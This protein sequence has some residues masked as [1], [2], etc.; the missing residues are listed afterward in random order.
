MCPS[1]LGFSSFSK[2]LFLNLYFSYILP[3]SV[4]SACI[5]TNDLYIFI[6][7]IIYITSKS[8]EVCVP[9]TALKM[10][11]VRT[12]MISYVPTLMTWSSTILFHEPLMT[13]LHSFNDATLFW[14]SSYLYSH[15]SPSLF[16][17]TFITSATT[18]TLQSIFLSFILFF[19]CRWACQL[20]SLWANVLKS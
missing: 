11:S 18:K 7:F 10:L 14:P 4:H 20:H 12:P 15:F 13:F 1:H 17:T 6:L 8:P 19:F 3:P 5:Y 9:T 16:L 2:C